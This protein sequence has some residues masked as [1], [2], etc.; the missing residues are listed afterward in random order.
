MSQ[1]S[2]AFWEDATAYCALIDSLANSK[3][4][5]SMNSFMLACLD[6]QRVPMSCRMISALGTLSAAAMK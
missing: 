3:P 2:R 1:Q 4:R 5:T 6:W